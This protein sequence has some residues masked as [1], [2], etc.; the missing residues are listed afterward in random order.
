MSILY[1]PSCL[2]ARLIGSRIYLKIPQRLRRSLGML[3]GEDM[4]D[5]NEMLRKIQNRIPK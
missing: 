2:L 4:S 5:L 3:C 1:W